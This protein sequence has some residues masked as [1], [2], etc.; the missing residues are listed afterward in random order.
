MA[1]ETGQKFFGF[2]SEK[3]LQLFRFFIGY[4]NFR[5][6]IL[7]QSLK[8]FYESYRFYII[9]VFLQLLRHLVLQLS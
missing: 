3:I 4:G 2:T 8:G 6:I 7:M 9:K 5:D 1:R